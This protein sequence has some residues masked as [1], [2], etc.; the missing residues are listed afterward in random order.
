[1]DQTHPVLHLG[2]E[3]VLIFLI[4][5]D[6]IQQ[7]QVHLTYDMVKGNKHK[8]S[9]LTIDKIKGIKKKVI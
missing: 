5:N 3:E 2:P 6:H 4:N 8:F 7:N 1:M 9:L